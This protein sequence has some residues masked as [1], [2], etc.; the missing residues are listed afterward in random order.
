MDSEKYFESGKIASTVTYNIRYTHYNGEPVCITFGLGTKF[1]VNAI[2][3][4]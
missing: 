1:S 4:L 3:G 2:I